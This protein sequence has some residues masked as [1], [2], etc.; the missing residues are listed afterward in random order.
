MNG[1]SIVLWG[2]ISTT[3]LT[4]II[5]AAQGLGFTRIDLPYMLGSLFSANRDR[6]KVIGTVIH[7]FN[8]WAF[9]ALYA[10]AFESWR[11]SSWWLGMG[12]GLF[13]AFFILAGVMRLLPSM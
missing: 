1:R 2:F 8:G 5:S 12:A 6:A 10:A 3:I 9:A 7:F 4:G 11:R 13:H